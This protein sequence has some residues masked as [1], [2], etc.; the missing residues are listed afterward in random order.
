M[1]LCGRVGDQPYGR[2][3]DHRQR[4]LGAGQEPGHVEAVLRQQVLQ[5][6][7]RDLPAEAAELGADGGQIGLHQRLQRRAALARAVE[8]RCASSAQ[9]RSPDPVTTSRATT[10]SAVLP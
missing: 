9:I 8:D 5:A 1:I 3:D 4:A 10:L 2:A 7:A 6:V